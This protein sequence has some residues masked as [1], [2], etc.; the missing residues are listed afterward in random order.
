MEAILHLLCIYYH[1]ITRQQPA[2]GAHDIRAGNATI[3][4]EGYGLRQRV[5]PSI[6]ASA[7][8]DHNSLAA[9]HGELFL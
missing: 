1:D 3:S 6:R 4:G 2:A 7:A 5:L 8:G 9:E